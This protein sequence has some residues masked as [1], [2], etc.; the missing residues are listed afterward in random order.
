MGKD[1]ECMDGPKRMQ[2]ELLQ[3]LDYKEL[4]AVTLVAPEK[5]NIFHWTALLMPY[6]PPYNKGAYKLDIVF[7]ERYPFVPPILR[8]VTPVYHPNINERGQLCIPI[9][10]SENWKP[11]SRMCTILNVV[12]ATFQDPV[13]ENAFDPSMATL[14]VK[15]RP[16]FEKIAMSWVIRYG[17]KR[18]TEAQLTK[19]KKRIRK[20]M[21]D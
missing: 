9:L 5:N 8:V 3:M 19:M 20:K 4:P 10:E 11:T 7:P 21:L 13:V 6:E 12:M 18:Y 17:E 16:K 2:N 15:D 1:E 14:Y